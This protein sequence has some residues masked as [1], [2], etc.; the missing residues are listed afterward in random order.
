M[1]L[2]LLTIILILATASLVIKK[3]VPAIITFASMMVLLGIY[4]MTL[5]EPLLGLFQIFVYTGG[6]VVL[7]LFGVTI[8]GIEFPHIAT[9]PWAAFSSLL[10][11]GVL[12][13]LFL[14]ASHTLTQVAG[15]SENVHLFAENYSDFVLLFAL[16]A[17]SLLYGTIKMAGVLR[18]KRGKNV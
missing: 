8:I 17:A 2:L 18:A 4:Y 15:V 1:N 10:V 12:T 3:S 9:R 14:R 16:I 13:A 6:V 7:M 5:H 11:F